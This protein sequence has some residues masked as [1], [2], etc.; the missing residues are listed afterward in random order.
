MRAHFGAGDEIDDAAIRALGF[1][2]LQSLEQIPNTGQGFVLGGRA[3]QNGQAGRDQAVIFSIRLRFRAGVV[4]TVNLDYIRRPRAHR[5]EILGRWGRILWSDEDGAAH[6]HDAG[7]DRV[8]LKFGG[9]SVASAENWA[10]I[11]SIIERRVAEGLRPVVVHSALKGVSIALDKLLAM[12]EIDHQKGRRDRRKH[13]GGDK[14]AP[15]DV[16]RSEGD[17]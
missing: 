2:L 16:Q 9:T 5:L 4:G 6:L 3:E 1:K 15:Q 13:K 17:Q 14:R 10:T 11:A 12:A 8:V 7:S